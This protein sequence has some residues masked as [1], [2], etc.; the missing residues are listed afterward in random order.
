MLPNRIALQYKMYKMSL[1]KNLFVQ[2]DGTKEDT[3]FKL[4]NYVLG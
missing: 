3:M 2:T 1:C 4:I